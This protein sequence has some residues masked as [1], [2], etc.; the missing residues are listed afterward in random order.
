VDSDN[1]GKTENFTTNITNYLNK[2]KTDAIP[3]VFPFFLSHSSKFKNNSEK[4]RYEKSVELLL[5]LKYFIEANPEKEYLIIKE[6][7][8][9]HGI[10]DDEFFR[11]ERL[12]K[13]K[14]FLFSESVNLNPRLSLRENL[15]IATNHD[16][17]ASENIKK[18]T[19]KKMGFTYNNAK[20]QK[21]PKFDNKY[22]ILHIILDIHCGNLK[23]L[24]R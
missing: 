14:R 18:P 20:V 7:F 19:N 11:A 21:D 22:V 9:N 13:F 16:D 15:V 10:Y 6:F 5:Q 24:L 2:K 17:Q 23:G 1:E 8:G 4:K 3:I 12:R